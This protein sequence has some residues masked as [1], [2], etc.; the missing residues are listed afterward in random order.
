[1]RIISLYCILLLTVFGQLRGQNCSSTLSQFPYVESFETGSGG[2]ANNPN[3]SLSFV[4]KNGPTPTPGTGPSSAIDGRFYYYVEATLPANF[5]SNAGSAI[6]E[7]PCYDLTQ[8]TDPQLVF[9]YHMFGANA[10]R[11]V[12]Q[13][14][15]DGGQSWGNSLLLLNG[16]QGN[17]WKTVTRSLSTWR[18]S[19]N[20]RIRFAATVTDVPNDEGDI[21]ID[22]IRIEEK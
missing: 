16:D 12:V 11:L 5:P 2:W 20:V 3:G 22:H 18:N 7:S 15:S 10:T 4:R 1:M 9:E 17:G 19:S 21:A 13:L 6:M 8:M 14:S